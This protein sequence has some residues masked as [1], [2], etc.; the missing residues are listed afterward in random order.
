MSESERKNLEGRLS[1]E[2]KMGLGEGGGVRGMEASWQVLGSR[3]R[4]KLGDTWRGS[5]PFHK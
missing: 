3:Y 1:G 2:N 5:D 4:L